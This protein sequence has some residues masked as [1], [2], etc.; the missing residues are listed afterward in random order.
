MHAD[1]DRSASSRR[2]EEILNAMLTAAAARRRVR[3]LRN[4]SLMCLPLGVAAGLLVF[5]ARHAASD[6]STHLPR[7][8]A[9]VRTITPEPTPPGDMARALPPDLTHGIIE[10][11]LSDDE[12]AGLLRESG[13]EMGLVRVGHEVRLVPWKPLPQVDAQAEPHPTKGDAAP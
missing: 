12:L 8:D 13:A 10:R 9:D 3:A 4:G 5:S 7:A 11:R 6:R 2:R 1:P